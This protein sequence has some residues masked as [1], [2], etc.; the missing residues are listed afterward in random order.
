M[1]RQHNRNVQTRTFPWT[2]TQD[3]FRDMT[4]STHC[5]TY[6]RAF[7]DASLNVDNMDGSADAHR[8]VHERVCKLILSV[9]GGCELY[10]VLSRA[11]LY[12][13][14]SLTADTANGKTGYWSSRDACGHVRYFMEAKCLR[15]HISHLQWQPSVVTA[16]VAPCRVIKRLVRSRTRNRSVAP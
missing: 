6:V 14:M 12:V 5:C 3:V 7:A 13:I 9:H 10:L 1:H 15:P 16:T 4:A 2:H 8:H 11:H